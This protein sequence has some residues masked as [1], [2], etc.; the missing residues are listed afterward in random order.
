MG[1]HELQYKRLLSELK[2]RYEELELM[3]ESMHDLSAEFEVYYAQFL[4]DN[5]ISKPELEE[6]DTPAFKKF[7]EESEAMPETDET[8]ISILEEK[9]DEYKEAKKVFTKL[10]RQI[11]MK[12]HP[13][14]IST[15]DPFYRNELTM[16]FKSAT[17]AMDKGKWS[18]LIK[19][20]EDLGI[21]PPNYKKMNSY[22]KK[23][24]KDVSGQVETHKLKFSWKLYE[25]E[26]K[27][28]KDSVIKN[29]IF[30]LFRKQI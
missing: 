3:E 4:E 21:K 1:I 27:E 10:Y 23:E 30:Q 2:F 5:N 29:F 25:A 15:E 17:Y 7:K 11:V 13:D 12:T 8:G 24:I 6:S 28:E 20:A 9:T 14:K 19:I 18:K 22:L 26:E 16:K